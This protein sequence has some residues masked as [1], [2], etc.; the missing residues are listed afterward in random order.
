MVDKPR[1]CHIV[2]RKEVIFRSTVFAFVLNKRNQRLF[3]SDFTYQAPE[4]RVRFMI[5]LDGVTEFSVVQPKPGKRLEQM[6]VV[7][8]F[9]ARTQ[10]ENR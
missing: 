1:H 6:R 9:P 7:R 8:R 5:Q 3:E 4:I 2:Q 10:C